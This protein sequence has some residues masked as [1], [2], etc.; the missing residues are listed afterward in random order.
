LK[1]AESRESK[2]H[3]EGRRDQRSDSRQQKAESRG[4][5]QSA[6]RRKQTADSR[7][8]KA[9]SRDQRAESRMGRKQRWRWTESGDG[10]A[11]VRDEI[12]ESREQRAESILR[13]E[14]RTEKLEQNARSKAW[15]GEKHNRMT[16]RWTP[17]ASRVECHHRWAAG[18]PVSSCFAILQFWRI[19][20]RDARRYYD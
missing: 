1:T 12:A 10:T 4:T 8:Q 9:E 13:K 19:G 7:N 15:S 6:E 17:V 18:E 20:G 3:E 16:C 11:D 5:T 2:K 14:H